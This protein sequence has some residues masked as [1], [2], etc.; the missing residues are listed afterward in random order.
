MAGDKGKIEKSE[1]CVNISGYA[2]RDGVS[3]SVTELTT[4]RQSLNQTME[5]VSTAWCQHNTL[6]PGQ[7][8]LLSTHGKR[9]FEGIPF[10]ENVS[11][12]IEISWNI[13][14]PVNTVMDLN[15]NP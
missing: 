10:K 13:I 12:E 8:E 15:F 1:P 9:N 3:K 4:T 7:I 11:I 6:K 5:G 2:A 14:C